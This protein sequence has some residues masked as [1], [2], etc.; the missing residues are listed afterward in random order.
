MSDHVP[1]FK[2]VGRLLDEERARGERLVR[3]AVVGAR[4][5][6]GLAPHRPK[7]R[8]LLCGHDTRPGPSCASEVDGVTVCHVASRVYRI[9]DL[10]RELRQVVDRIESYSGG[11]RPPSPPVALLRREID[12]RGELAELGAP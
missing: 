7:H 10:R 3:A 11:D 2:Y 6:L 9:D 5:E 8:T 4:A 1:G 12:I